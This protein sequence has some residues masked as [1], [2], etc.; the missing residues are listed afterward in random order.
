MNASGK[1]QH[2]LEGELL[3]QV[4]R[5]EQANLTHPT[6]TWYSETGSPWQITALRSIALPDGSQISFEGQAEI[7]RITQSDHKQLKITSEKFVVRPDEQTISSEL[8]VT[9]EVADGQATAV[10]FLANLADEEI[11]LL[12][13]VEGVYL[14]AK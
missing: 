5:D 3:R 9:I 2:R 10:G 6:L 8:L 7:K 13:Q 11:Q 1:P 14:H 12:N 4:K